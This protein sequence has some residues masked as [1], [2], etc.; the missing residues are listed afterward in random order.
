VF[1]I[2]SANGLLAQLDGFLSSQNITQDGNG[3]NLSWSIAQGNT[4]IGT[5]VERSINDGPF[6]RVYFIGGICGSPDR[7][8]V[9]RWRDEDLTQSGNYHYRLSFGN[10]GFVS[11]IVTFTPVWESG[12]VVYQIS[13]SMGHAIRV[14]AFNGT[15]SIEVYDDLGHLI[16]ESGLVNQREIFL[17]SESWENGVYIA[18]I[19][20]GDNMERAKFAIYR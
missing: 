16:Y 9:Y 1:L 6:E 10:L 3:I 14:E 20:S 12:M 17:P 7:E 8:E 11:L 13:G 19:R 4:C 5:E 18:I 2:L 15:Y